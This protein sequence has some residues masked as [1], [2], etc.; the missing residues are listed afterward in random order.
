MPSPWLAAIAGGL[1]GLGAGKQRH[2]QMQLQQ[3]QAQQLQQQ[4]MFD[5]FYKMESLRAGQENT[6]IDQQLRFAQ[7]RGQ[8][9]QQQAQQQQQEFGRAKE[10]IGAVPLGDQI[11][12]PLA[13][14]IQ[15]NPAL[16][17]LVR[18]QAA[19]APSQAP[20]TLPGQH[21]LEGMPQAPTSLPGLAS[22]GRPGS[23]TR[24][25]NPAEM[26]KVAH[27][28]AVKELLTEMG[29]NTPMAKLIHAQEATGKTLP[30]A[31]FG[32]DTTINAPP[33]PQKMTLQE[34]W[35]A[36]TDPAKKDAI[37]QALN[38]TD[39]PGAGAGV[40]GGASRPKLSVSQQNALNSAKELLAELAAL[41]KEGDV[42]EWAGIG[43]VAGRVGDAA[44]RYLP[45]GMQGVGNLL[46][47]GGDS[48]A[49][50]RA[51]FNQVT[52]DIA[53][54]KFGSAFTPNEQ[55][56]L[57]KIALSPTQN[58]AQARINILMMTD[59]ARK[60]IQVLGYDPDEEMA[61]LGGGQAPPPENTE[62]VYQY[63]GGAK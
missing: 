49:K 36:E 22:L 35:L 51:R 7:I 57:S 31:G 44:Y 19:Q 18:Q 15:R 46:G 24:T 33:T 2:D 28:E 62:T 60:K 32:I 8:L 4:R 30:P 41:T 17:G 34:R 56:M 63:R 25:P 27:A 55:A 6:G 37:K 11:P 21:D 43:P 52:S 48:G 14:L 5:N 26:E 54:A 20:V 39:N 47:G 53:H 23:M 40:P 42:A 29:P 45:E 61:A 9:G 50:L 10:G 38:L 16:A 58:A 3:Q 13:A 12:A 59:M 1:S